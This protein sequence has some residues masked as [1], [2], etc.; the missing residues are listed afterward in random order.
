MRNIK[1]IQ[2]WI[3]KNNIDFFILNRSDEFLNE[4][5]A[6]Y[7]ER[8]NWVSNF[9]GSAGRLIILQN[10]AIIFT[11]GRYTTQ[12]KKQVDEKYFINKHINKYWNW[13]ENHIKKNTITAVDTNL[14][15]IFE[16]NK[17]KNLIKSKKSTL[18]FLSKNPIDLFWKNQPGYPK[19]NAF[20]HRKKYSGKTVKQKINELCLVLKKKSIDYYFLN[21]L[22]SIAWLLNIRGKDI[23]YTPFV[24][25]YAIISKNKRV[26]LFMN[27][28]KTKLI[29]KYLQNYVDFFPLSHIQIFFD[30]FNKNLNIGMDIYRT[31]Y[32]FKNLCDSHNIKIKYVDDPIY[33]FKSQKNEIEI[34]GAIKS[35][36]RD[37]LSITKF[38]FWLKNKMIISKNNEISASKYLYNLR[39][40]NYLYFSLSFETISAIGKNAALPHYRLTQ[41]SNLSFRKNTIYLVD[42]GAQYFD[43]TTDITR[44]LVIGN[45]SK[46]QKDRFTRV[47]KGHIAIATKEFNNTTTGSE[48]D[49]L[50]RKSLYEIGCD[51]DHG[52]G[53]GIGSFSSVHEGPQRISKSNQSNNDYIKE[54]MILSNEPGFYK[55]DQYGIRIENLI[56]VVKKSKKKLAFKTISLAPIDIDLIDKKLLTKNEIRWVNDYHKKVRL[57]LGKF[58]KLKEKDWLKNVTRN[59]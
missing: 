17:L 53:H 18:E 56:L 31:N 54:G 50:A 26:N 51:Y 22:D 29:K 20:F 3:K 42:S 23:P 9:T 40:K 37:G 16:I 48:L 19:T 30:K 46:E 36:L 41:E 47:L 52:T 33:Y 8:L 6:P 10:E 58:L 13:L 32:Y 4:Y 12:V 5:L 7:A 39:K 28:K 59:L 11:D 49:P 38:I 57:S 44:T 43:G 21:S 24:F 14:H 2:N 1:K 25:C 45:P 15:S 35:N 34:K 27:L 55:K